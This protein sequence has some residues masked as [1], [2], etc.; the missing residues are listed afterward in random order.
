M[1]VNGTIAHQRIQAPPPPPV[2]WGN[3]VFWAAVAVVLAFSTL[4]QVTLVLPRM[5]EWET[6]LLEMEQK[7]LERQR[8]EEALLELQ[9]KHWKRVDSLQRQQRV[10]DALLIVEQEKNLKLAREVSDKLKGGE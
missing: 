4:V 5:G 6:K 2:W 1:N 7:F 3:N 8:K 10:N 9:E